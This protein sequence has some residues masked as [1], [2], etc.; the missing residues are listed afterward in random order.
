MPTATT[1]SQKG[2]PR[3]L[4]STR[5]LH[6]PWIGVRKE[7]KCLKDLK[8]NKYVNVAS[9]KGKLALGMNKTLPGRVGIFPKTRRNFRFNISPI[10]SGHF[11]CLFRQRVLFLVHPKQNVIAVKEDAQVLQPTRVVM[12]QAINTQS[13]SRPSDGQVRIRPRGAT[14]PSKQA[15]PHTSRMTLVCPINT[16]LKFLNQSVHQTDRQAEGLPFFCNCY[17]Y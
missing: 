13:N 10:R 11:R 2:R 7:S 12:S 17:N 14:S 6:R 1:R 8:L 16:Q 4:V 5:G 15:Y 9:R 3:A